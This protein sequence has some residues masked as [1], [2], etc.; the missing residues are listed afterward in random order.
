MAA[1]EFQQLLSTTFCRLHGAAERRVEEDESQARNEVDED[2]AEPKID[3]E[4]DVHVLGDERRQVELAADHRR[5]RV[6]VGDHLETLHTHLNEP[7]Q[8]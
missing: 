4:V 3:V 6:D 7:C 5:V 2:N 1:V 8:L